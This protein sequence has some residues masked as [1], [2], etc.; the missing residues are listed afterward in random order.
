MNCKDIVKQ[1][2]INNGYD[3]LA[4]EECGCTVDDTIGFMPCL[5]SESA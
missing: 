3:G 1:Y 4:G 2:L 5:D